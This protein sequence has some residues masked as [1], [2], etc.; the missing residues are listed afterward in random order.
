MRVRIKPIGLQ[1]WLYMNGLISYF[2]ESEVAVARLTYSF[3]Q[4]AWG[5]AVPRPS[6]DAY[7]WSEQPH[8]E[9]ELRLYGCDCR[10][11]LSSGYLKCGGTDG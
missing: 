6:T 3:R 5:D 2:P 1:T 4:L 7:E 9:S 8:R 10:E 11:G